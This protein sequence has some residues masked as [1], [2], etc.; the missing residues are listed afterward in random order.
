MN[1]TNVKEIA[2]YNVIGLMDSITI[3]CDIEAELVR[4]GEVVEANMHLKLNSNM[5][6]EFGFDGSPRIVELRPGIAKTPEELFDKIH[7][8]WIKYIKTF[9]S[10]NK[11]FTYSGK[12]FSTGM[13]LHAGHPLGLPVPVKIMTK[14][15]HRYLGHI[16]SL[17][18]SLVR[19]RTS[20]G[21]TIFANFHSAIE[22]KPY[23]FEY[24][25]PSAWLAQDKRAF[26][27]AYNIFTNVI[28]AVFSGR[29][30]DCDYTTPAR[31]SEYKNINISIDDVQYLTRHCK[32]INRAKISCR[33]ECYI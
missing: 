17:G 29:L 6:S 25:T 3:G 4:L 15:L 19:S 21:D 18:N 28:K 7:L 11:T 22:T 16:A 8:L 30:I 12:K 24:R 26:C 32:R 10:T 31:L 1:K 2:K 27:I 33:P 23:G 20:Y 9:D 5:N 13:H 14:A